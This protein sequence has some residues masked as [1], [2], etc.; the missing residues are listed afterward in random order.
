MI[1][2]LERKKAAFAESMGGEVQEGTDLHGS[3]GDLSSDRA[4][5]EDISDQD[6]NSE[7]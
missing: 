3:I 4:V 6:D 7:V 1:S 2:E 5:Q